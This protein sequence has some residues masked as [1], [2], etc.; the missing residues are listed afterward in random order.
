V[1]SSSKNVTESAPSEISAANAKSV[2]S[3][4]ATVSAQISPLALRKSLSC[5]DQLTSP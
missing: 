1:W 3:W 5:S 4:M 2:G